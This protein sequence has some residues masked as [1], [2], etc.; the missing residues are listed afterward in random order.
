[1]LHRH[2]FTALGIAMVVTTIVMT[3]FWQ[4]LILITQHWNAATGCLACINKFMTH[5]FATEHIVALGIIALTSFGLLRVIRLCLREVAF[6]IQHH[7]APSANHI[8]II[9][10]SKGTAWS[11]GFF[12][13]Q[14]FVS[15]RFWRKLT[16]TERN[17]VIAHE[18]SHVT[19]RDMLHFF[20]LGWSQAILP[21]PLVTNII[22]D[23][24]ERART[25]SEY[26]ADQAAI[27]ATSRTT[28]AE[29]LRKALL[30]QQTQH[31]SIASPRIDELLEKRV[32]CITMQQCE[33]VYHT[34][35]KS[36]LLSAILITLSIATLFW[37][38]LEAMHMCMV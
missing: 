34:L 31:L 15:R 12:H 32:R 2:H 21:L 29:V 13:P 6:A 22:R 37:A 4:S 7:R 11:N 5:F 30:F 3:L 25:Q 28:L 36:Y 23:L 16:H 1:M 26:L 10:K 9:K 27:Q 35:Q 38:S 18:Q 8:H 33:V 24:T 20:L 14:I 19:H 17:A